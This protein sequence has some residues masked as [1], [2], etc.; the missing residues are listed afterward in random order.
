MFPWLLTVQPIPC[1][2]GEEGCSALA[3]ALR[4]TT[5]LEALSLAAN[6][7]G[8]V[9]GEALAYA[10]EANCSLR[11]LDLA[12]NAFGPEAGNKLRAA[13]EINSSLRA[14]DVRR[15]GQLPAA[16]ISMQHA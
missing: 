16:S 12:S 6:A 8:P 10:L 9:A 13:V 5:Q 15:W 7:G 1:R 4:S 3:A 11:E 2:L 14:I